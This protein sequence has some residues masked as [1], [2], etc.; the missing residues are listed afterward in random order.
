MLA[1]RPTPF[2]ERVGRDGD[3]MPMSAPPE[4]TVAST[5]AL[6]STGHKMGMRAHA[7]PAMRARCMKPGA[8]DHHSKPNRMQARAAIH[9]HQRSPPEARTPDCSMGWRDLPSN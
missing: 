2:P 7:S 1:P 9:I 4:S 8:I 6:R 5:P 3:G